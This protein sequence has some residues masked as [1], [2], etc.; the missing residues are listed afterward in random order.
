MKKTS[1]TVITILR[2]K[3]RA[4]TFVYVWPAM[5]ATGL[6]WN[7]LGDSDRVSRAPAAKKDEARKDKFY[8]KVEAGMNKCAHITQD[9][10]RVF[11]QMNMQ[12][13]AAFLR[14]RSATT[15]DVMIIVP[16]AVYI[17]ERMLGALALMS[18]IEREE[19]K[20]DFEINFSTADPG[21]LNTLAT[22]GSIISNGYMYSL[23]YDEK[24]LFKGL[25]TDEGKRLKAT[26]AKKQ[27]SKARRA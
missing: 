1:R 2:G 17:S 21:N 23:T 3:R 18:K 8:S 22:Q 24:K 12:P 25:R 19:E 27:K 15:F 10:L 6:T 16:S 11:Y 14:T 4:L 20:D 5:A 7:K 26:N 13:K 9:L